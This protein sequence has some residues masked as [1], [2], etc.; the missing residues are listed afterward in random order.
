MKLVEKSVKKPMIKFLAKFKWKTMMSQ[1]PALR[2]ASI[3]KPIEFK[4]KKMKKLI[5][6]INKIR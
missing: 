1:S 4:R 5:N 6:I 3:L 2:E